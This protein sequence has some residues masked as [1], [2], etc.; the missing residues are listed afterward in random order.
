MIHFIGID[1]NVIQIDNYQDVIDIV[2]ENGKGI[3]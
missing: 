1:Q 2:L 3:R